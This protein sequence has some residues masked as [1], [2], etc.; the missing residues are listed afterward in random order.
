MTEASNPSG[1]PPPRFAPARRPRTV[2]AAG[3]TLLL[4]IAGAL[5]VL[6]RD[7]PV[8][9]PA[10]S[11]PPLAAQLDRLLQRD[12]GALAAGVAVRPLAAVDDDAAAREA[13]APVCDAVVASLA[14][15]PGLRVPA[16]SS[17]RVALAA[18]LDDAALARLLAVR[19]V[20][21]GEIA[22]RPGGR[23]QVRL[24]MHDV[25]GA[26]ERWRIEHEG[27]PHELQALPA[28]VAQRTAE[29]LGVAPPP[30]PAAPLPA[31]LHA[32]HLDAQRKARRPSLDDRRAALA[33]VEALLQEVP[34]HGALQ[35]M[36]LALRSSL[37]AAGPDPADR[38]R[39]EAEL[40]ARQSA[41]LAEIRQLGEQ[42]L[43]QD[44][45]D[46]RAHVL[47]LNHAYQGGRMVEALARADALVQHAARHPG[48][49]RIAARTYTHAG[50]LA[51]AREL[52][53]QAARLDALDSEAH[54]V[55]AQWHGMRGDTA[56]ML[57]F[58]AVAEQL[59]HRQ[60]GLLR[61][62]AALRGRDWG[63]AAQAFSDWSRGGGRDGGWVA[64][65]VQ[66]LRDP[67]AR[68]AATDALQAEPEAVR[69][70]MVGHFFEHA[71][72]GD[73]A[74]SLAAVQRHAQMP[75]AAW[76][77]HLW[78]PE[79]APLR[80][81]PRFAGIVEDLGL[82]ALWEARGAPDLCSAGADGRWR[83]R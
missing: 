38:A 10:D 47:L 83:C 13:G 45:A 27:A 49:L 66:G 59:G 41:L 19:H 26:G 67:T 72:L 31:A 33:E 80:A 61:G 64:S 9:V 29:V 65:F 68:A 63:A 71:M 22:S 44:P 55:L 50:Y 37:A 3:L 53:L 39:S 35:Y 6:W 77:Q 82:V 36:R 34:D 24:A 54:E 5:V 76:L 79:L 57:E 18:G 60:T 78:W 58:V 75:P 81:H 14:R 69:S 8:A 48:M 74:R 40:K 28:L 70:A 62:I 21:A 52:A 17:T 4:L 25:G 2:L 56:G 11:E 46:W 15:M 32:R 73:A 16:C 12:G 1:S 23:L 42:L 30:P 7:R 51:Q 20:V 43:A